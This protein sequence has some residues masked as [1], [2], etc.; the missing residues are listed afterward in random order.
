MCVCMYVCIT[1]MDV[2]NTLIIK[3]SIIKLRNIK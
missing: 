1:Q 2:K 3:L